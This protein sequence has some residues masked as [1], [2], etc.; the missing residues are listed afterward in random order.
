MVKLSFE[1]LKQVKVMSK[2]DTSKFWIE[3][4]HYK[5]RFQISNTFVGTLIV[6]SCVVVIITFHKIWIYIGAN[7]CF[8]PVQQHSSGA[9]Q[10][11]FSNFKLIQNWGRFHWMISETRAAPFKCSVTWIQ[12]DWINFISVNN[13]I[14]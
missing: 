13:E 11:L 2:P 14:Q 6:S 7:I 1:E 4:K 10:I 9:E 8:E 5:T 12:L 3:D